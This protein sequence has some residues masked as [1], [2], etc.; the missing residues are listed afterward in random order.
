MLLDRQEVWLNVTIS[1]PSL[2]SNM[3]DSFQPEVFGYSVST[4]TI[5]TYR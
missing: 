5:G 3:P 2:G 4:I 1:D